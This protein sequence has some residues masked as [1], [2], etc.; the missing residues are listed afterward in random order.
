MDIFFVVVVDQVA[1]AQCLKLNKRSEAA[2]AA[3]TTVTT[4]TTT[5]TSAMTRIHSTRKLEFEP[6]FS[7]GFLFVH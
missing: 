7:N 3:A 1:S 5:S 6:F 2:A 4:A